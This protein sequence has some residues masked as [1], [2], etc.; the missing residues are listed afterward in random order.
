[1]ICIIRKSR[2]I[3]DCSVIARVIP[4]QDRFI[5]RRQVPLLK[6]GF[7]PSKSTKNP[8]VLGSNGK[9]SGFA[10]GRTGFVSTCGYPNITTRC[11][12]WQNISQLFVRSTPACTISPGWSTS[13]DINH[14]ARC[15]PHPKVPV[16][17]KTVRQLMK[18]RQKRMTWGSSSRCSPIPSDFGF[19]PFANPAKQTK[20]RYPKANPDGTGDHEYEKERKKRWFFT[21]ILADNGFFIQAN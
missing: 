2:R 16:A 8:Q 20:G 10:I 11:N 9:I 14:G 12:A 1:M 21:K 18:R 7:I 13:I 15:V 5:G 6:R 4:A 17:K 19:N 3:V